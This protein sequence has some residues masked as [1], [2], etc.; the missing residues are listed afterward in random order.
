MFYPTHFPKSRQARISTRR[1]TIKVCG[2]FRAIS[3]LAVVPSSL[4]LV[5]HPHYRYRREEIASVSHVHMD[6]IRAQDCCGIIASRSPGNDASVWWI[7]GSRAFGESHG[8]YHQLRLCCGCLIVDDAR[9]HQPRRRAGS[10]YSTPVWVVR[11]EHEQRLE[12]EG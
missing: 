6:K 7:S 3:C 11:P 10:A 12:Y 1:T 8:S 9:H 5:P 2:K 4:R